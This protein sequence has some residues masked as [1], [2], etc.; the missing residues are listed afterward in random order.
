ME[1]TIH[2]VDHI[3]RQA[4]KIK[5]ERSIP[6][7]EALDCACRNAGFSSYKTFLNKN[8]KN[9]TA[10]TNRS[11]PTKKKND[12]SSGR[13]VTYVK[14]VTPLPYTRRDIEKFRPGDEAWIS[15]DGKK[16]LPVILTEVDDIYYTF[17]I[18]RPLKSAGDQH[19]LRLDEVRST[20]ELACKNHVTW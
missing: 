7:H 2:T 20:P 17:K 4:K 19:Y 18:E 6:H 1:N 8:A 15:W 3:K 9:E 13:R 14:G 10:P 16:A 11:Q 5:K 12:S